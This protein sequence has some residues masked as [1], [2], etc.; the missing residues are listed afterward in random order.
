MHETDCH[1]VQAAGGQSRN[2]LAAFAAEMID[3]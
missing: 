3:T 1:M 2:G